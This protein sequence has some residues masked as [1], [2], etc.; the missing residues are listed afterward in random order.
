M[1]L[2]IDYGDIAIVAF[3]RLNA[4]H[5]LLRCQLYKCD[6]PPIFSHNWELHTPYG[7][8]TRDRRKDAEK[9]VFVDIWSTQLLLP[10]RR[11]P[12]MRFKQMRFRRQGHN[13]ERKQ[14]HVQPA[15]PR[16]AA[17]ISAGVSSSACSLVDRLP[18]IP[19]CSRKALLLVQWRAAPALWGIASCLFRSY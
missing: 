11:H 6:E 4:T 9:R 19:V 18:L 17:S 5:R 15:D 2:L 16:V 13:C 10:R 12:Q 1:K 3:V 7:V 8:H 14:T